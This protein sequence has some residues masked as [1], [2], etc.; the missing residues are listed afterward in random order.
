MAT[1]PDS[2]STELHSIDT[3]GGAIAV[4]PL[5]AGFTLR[6]WPWAALPG[7]GRMGQ[8]ALLNLQTEQTV[9]VA[10]TQDQVLDCTSQWCQVSTMLNGG[11][12]VEHALMRPDGS[13]YRLLSRD[14]GRYPVG[15]T[16]LLG[17]FAVQAQAAPQDWQP[18]RLW[19]LDIVSDRT[20]LA[21]ASYTLQFGSY[22]T[23]TWWSSGD[24]EAL[25]W[26]LLDLRQLIS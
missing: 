10:G 6:D 20:A 17:R 24:N 23:Y 3:A 8:L 11:S 12:N 13:A 16:P 14:D 2:Q 25:Q 21:S 26:N 5:S 19:L 18:D 15:P 22:G 9:A 4:R 1:T 7:P